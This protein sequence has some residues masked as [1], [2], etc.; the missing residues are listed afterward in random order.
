MFA[1]WATLKLQYT[2]VIVKKKTLSNTEHK[3]F[4][5]CLCL[6]RIYTIHACNHRQHPQ[7]SSCTNKSLVNNSKT[8]YNIQAIWILVQCDLLRF[9]ALRCSRVH[10]WLYKE[11]GKGACTT[12]QLPHTLSIAWKQTKENKKNDKI[13]VRHQ[14]SPCSASLQYTACH[15]DMLYT[16][17]IKHSNGRWR[18]RM[19]ERVFYSTLAHAIR[20]LQIQNN[21]KSIDNCDGIGQQSLLN[22]N[23]HEMCCSALSVPDQSP[24]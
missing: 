19:I 24:H 14:P 8:I 3:F 5:I 7:K 10:A 17:K 2:R 11:W 6:A 23:K 1:S 12:K 20:F 22:L 9:N 18:I 16:Q 15:L 21:K 4:L 13:S